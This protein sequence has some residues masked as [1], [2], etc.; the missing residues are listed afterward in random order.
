MP[1]PDPNHPVLAR[2]NFLRV[3]GL[4]LAGMLWAPGARPIS[5]LLGVDHHIA[6]PHS[7]EIQQAV[8]NMDENGLLSR[9]GLP[10][11]TPYTQG[12]VCDE[13]VDVRE[14]PDF[15][16]KR[17]AVLWKDTIFPITGIAI[18]EDTSSH[19]LVW[20]QAGDQGYVHS[21]A[22]QPVRT[23]LNEVDLGIPI[24]GA[25]AE[26]TVPF[27][28]AH[29]TPSRDG[30]VAYR[31]YFETTHWVTGIKQD[32]D[33]YAWYAV[34][35]DKYKHTY[36][37]Q[38]EHLRIVPLDELA[39]ISPLVPTYE[40]RI[41][42]LLSDQILIAY[43]RAQSVFFTRIASGAVFSTGTYTTPPGVYQ[44]FHKRPSRHMAAGDLASNGYD[45]PGVPWI[46]YITQSGIAIHGTYWHNNFG[47]PRSHGCINVSSQ[48]SKWIYLWSSPTVPP[49]EQMRY[50]YSGTLV[51]VV[52]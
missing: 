11:F 32:A 23:Q 27:S 4:A 36:Y 5:N 22:V 30:L 12:R 15:K 47:R 10:Q 52:E 44:T 31:F 37:V 50:E 6:M 24:E 9:T 8:R 40:K 45:L 49:H 1:T 33:G 42:V 17:N 48:A 46:N 2:R 13:F 14:S 43:E 35:D 21:G 20:Y 16:G 39:P 51:E 41:R 28:D 25:L 7:D 38:H 3:G 19:N 34:F 18:S 26:V 29:W